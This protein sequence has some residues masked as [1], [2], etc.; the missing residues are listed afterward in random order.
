MI[1]QTKNT[2]LKKTLLLVLL[3]AGLILG[4]CGG[5]EESGSADEGKKIVVCTTTMIEDLGHVLA[6][7]TLDIRGIMKTGEDPHI[8][9]FTPQD[10]ILIGKADLILMNGLHLEAQMGHVVDEQAKGKV[11]KLANDPRIVTAEDEEGAPDPHCW[12]HPEFYKIYVEKARDA[13]VEVDPDN[14]ETYKSRAAD[15]AKELDAIYAWGKQAIGEIPEER[16][17]LVTSHDAF[18]YFGQAFGIQVAAVGGISTE[19]DPTPQDRIKLEGVIK[20]SGA[21][22]LF[23]ESSVRDSLN[24]MIK[25]IAKATGAKV[26]GELHSD[27]LGPK[28]EGADTYLTMLKHNLSTVIDALK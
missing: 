18:Q 5:G 1:R 21:K 17:I 26:G 20:E 7:D 10:T 24:T 25:Q 23:V 16:R 28:G 19:T 27:S 13:L 8:Y 3:A 22:A 9:E 6:G 15:Y 2:L 14:A 4:G 12:F 11:V